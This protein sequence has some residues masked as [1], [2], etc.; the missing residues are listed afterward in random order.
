MLHFFSRIISTWLVLSDIFV[1]K[2]AIFNTS[3]VNEICLLATWR[4]IHIY[5]QRTVIFFSNSSAC[6]TTQTRFV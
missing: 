3:R 5:T 6:T 4:K 2:N 1:V